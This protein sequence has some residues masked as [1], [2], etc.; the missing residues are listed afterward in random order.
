MKLKLY[1][2]KFKILCKIMKLEL[3][4]LKKQK[5][6]AEKYSDKITTLECEPIFKKMDERKRYL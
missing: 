3:K 4:A 5:Q 6:I 1:N 2:L